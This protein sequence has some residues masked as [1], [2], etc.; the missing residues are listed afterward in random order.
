MVT[1]VSDAVGQE[2]VEQDMQMAEPFGGYDRLEVLGSG[3]MGVVYLAEQRSTGRKVALKIIRPELLHLA[4]AR[5]RFQREIEAV[6]S[7]DDPGIC[8]VYDAGEVAGVPYVA[9]RYVEGTSLAH[10]LHAIPGAGDGAAAPASSN[11]GMRSTRSGVMATVEFFE[12]IA[13]SLHTAHQAGIVHRDIKP[14]NIMVDSEGDPVIVDFGLARAELGGEGDDLT[15]TGD[16]LGTPAYMSPEQV[17]P[18]TKPLDRRTDVYSLGVALYEALAG[19]HPFDTTTRQQLE[20]KIL[21]GSAPDLCRQNR[22]VP[23]DLRTVVATAMDVDADR[24]YQ[25][26]ET[27]AE[28]LRRVRL[29]EPIR[30]KRASLPARLLAWVRREPL[31]AALVLVLVATAGLAGFVIAGQEARDVGRDALRLARLERLL[32][33]AIAQGAH[34]GELDAL[35]KFD[36]ILAEDPGNP[37]AVAGKAMMLRDLGRAPEALALVESSGSP[38]LHALRV[39]LLRDLQRDAEAESL[40]QTLGSPSNAV[41]FFVAGL[42]ASRQ[43]HEAEDDRLFEQAQQLWTNAILHSQVVRRIHLTELLH[44]ARH[45]MDRPSMRDA[46]QAIRGNWPDELETWHAIAEAL[47]VLDPAAGIANCD[48]ILVVE[49]EHAPTWIAK[50]N[51]LYQLEQFDDAFAAYGTALSFEPNHYQAA[52]RQADCLHRQ[53]HTKKAFS[54]LTRLSRRF[55]GVVM[56]P[57]KMAQW[58]LAEGRLEEAIAQLKRAL[59][60][61]RG[62]ALD[63]AN[64]VQAL[65]SSGQLKEAELAVRA[66]IAAHPE[67]GKILA[68]SGFVLMASGR[69]QEA[70]AALERAMQQMPPNSY[71]HFQLGTAYEQSG[72][73]DKSLEQFEA[74]HR[75]APH[76]TQAKL[77]VDRVRAKI[78]KR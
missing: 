47:A 4:K 41:A 56:I 78:E 61:G 69:T 44:C 3:G 65:L 48:R 15:M 67:D 46:I 32:S 27:F 6:A 31:R 35:P 39:A 51:A 73:L 34:G 24:R 5:R 19:S 68:A 77:A 54:T 75:L 72:R 28:D 40:A 8:T 49:P 70:I 25:D 9:M 52:V 7:L 17:V 76:V 33:T 66:A 62:D 53:G 55:P 42:L 16:Q 23:R 22:L 13:R 63:H 45:M 59:I 14:G 10:L 74:S 50:A 64:L 36:A 1:P 38:D 20:A 2:A 58:M 21:A 57:Q 12:R 29:L 26:A 71:M 43:A 18:G 60:V 30:A 11:L 37:E